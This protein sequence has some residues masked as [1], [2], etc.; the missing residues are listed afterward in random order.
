MYTPWMHGEATPRT[1]WCLR[2]WAGSADALEVLHLLLLLLGG[3]LRL[4]NDVL[5]EG[6][7]A[8]L[9]FLS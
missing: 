4:G 2:R 9:E 3:L 7:S 8:F 1:R 5:S 6:L